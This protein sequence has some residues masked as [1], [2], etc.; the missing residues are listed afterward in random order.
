MKVKRVLLFR[1]K[2]REYLNKYLPHFR[3]KLN[4]VLRL[5]TDIKREQF[6]RLVNLIIAI[7]LNE[8]SFHLLKEIKELKQSIET[9]NK[10][11]LQKSLFI[12]PVLCF[13]IKALARFCNDIHNLFQLQGKFQILLLNFHKH[14]RQLNVL[15]DL[16][17]VQEAYK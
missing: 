7:L 8:L 4:M 15:L 5:F 12:E 11:N 2:E 17:C 10:F 6:Q 16:A 14:F 9:T 1:V 3:I 13:S